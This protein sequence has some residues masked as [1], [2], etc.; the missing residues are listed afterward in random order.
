MK[1]LI[2]L[3]VFFLAVLFYGLIR[4]DRDPQESTRIDLQD[5]YVNRVPAE[6]IT[7]IT[8]EKTSDPSD[9]ENERVDAAPESIIDPELHSFRGKV[10][11]ASSYLPVKEFRVAVYRKTAKEK[12][13][14]W[15]AWGFGSTIQNDQGCFEIPSHVDPGYLY[16]IVAAVSDFKKGASVSVEAEPGGFTEDL[17]ILLEPI[18][19]IAGTVIDA[20]TREPV[21]EALIYSINDAGRRLT[22]NEDLTQVAHAVS[23]HLGKFRLKIRSPESH[24][25]V[26]RHADYPEAV[27]TEV[28]PGAYVEIPMQKG[29]RIHGTAFD[30]LGQPVEGALVRIEKKGYSNNHDLSQEILTLKQGAFTSKSL[31]KGRYK[32]CLKEVPGYP[33][34]S[35]YFGSEE[36]S[37]IQGCECEIQVGRC[38]GN[39]GLAGVLMRGEAPVSNAKIIMWGDRYSSDNPE[40]VESERLAVTDHNGRFYLLGFKPHGFWLTIYLEE[41]YVPCERFYVNI[42][43]EEKELWKIQ[44][45]PLKQK[46]VY[47]DEGVLNGYLIHRDTGLPIQGS[48]N[49]CYHYTSIFSQYYLDRKVKIQNNGSF[50]IQ[51]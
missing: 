30:P 48:G 44:L 12:Q 47:L 16:R 9:A 40:P 24:T 19:S 46:I 13:A 14:P 18:P 27:I 32:V 4:S 17:A 22:C 5:R 49:E 31:P 35:Y 39:G 20:E 28:E 10:L 43:P 45:P 26:A 41:E 29:F 8:E 50:E 34:S 15:R 51:G 6:P 1:I 33:A 21:E 11:E 3:G 25:L 42:F 37:L 23:D 2:P 36:V 38:P 7:Q